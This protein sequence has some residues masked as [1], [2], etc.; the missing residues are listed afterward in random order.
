DAE[1]C[2]TATVVFPQGPDKE[3][4]YA[5]PDELLGRLQ[6]GC[7]VKVPLGRGDRPVVGYCVRLETKRLGRK[8]KE[9]VEPVDNVPL[10]RPPMIRLTR[11]MSDYYLCD[12][13]QVLESVVPAGVRD[14]AGTR[15][16][17]FLTLADEWRGKIDE[18]KLP[19]KQALILQL[20]EA[21]RE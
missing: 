11:W 7:R 19:K 8:L 20:L 14:A 4:D 3:Y 2:A 17:T 1:L 6:E 9:I 18:L 21:S 10:L 16:T 12:W 5:V 13:G 15:L